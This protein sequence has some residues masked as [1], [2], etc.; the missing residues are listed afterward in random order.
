LHS[1]T[2]AAS[3]SPRRSS[4]WLGATAPLFVTRGVR[5]VDGKPVAAHAEATAPPRSAIGVTALTSLGLSDAGGQLRV[6]G[7]L[8]FQPPSAAVHA[9][10]AG[11]A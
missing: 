1:T 2:S 10:P 4:A 6:N 3:R 11:R 5:L 8:V 7:V 9:P